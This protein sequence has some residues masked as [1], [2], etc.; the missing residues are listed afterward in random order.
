MILV[1]CGC[2][3]TFPVADSKAGQTIPCPI[4]KGACDVPSSVV[5]PVSPPATATKSTR[6]KAI[7]CPGC[8]TGIP[9]PLSLLRGSVQCNICGQTLNIRRR[10]RQKPALV[11]RYRSWLSRTRRE[12][13]RVAKRVFVALSLILW[14]VVIASGLLYYYADRISTICLSD[15][16]NAFMNNKNDGKPMSSKEVDALRKKT[17]AWLE[18]RASDPDVRVVEWY[19]SVALR[20][21][22]GDCWIALAYR[23]K[24]ENGAWVRMTGAW[25]FSKGEINDPE[26][27]IEYSDYICRNN[28]AATVVR[29]MEGEDKFVFVGTPTDPTR[30]YLTEGRILKNL[31]DLNKKIEKAKKSKGT[32]P[33]TD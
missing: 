14:L 24:N 32:G 2:G 13:G 1:T 18:S 12:A 21:R 3:R 27:K 10:N 33:P 6:I 23:T 5:N 28:Y 9:V 31:Q 17:L 22:P 16:W 25:Y 19:P 11:A 8:A 29:V 4:C 26:Q 20:E 30:V 15:A 7:R